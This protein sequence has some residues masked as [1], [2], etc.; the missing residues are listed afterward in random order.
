LDKL[1]EKPNLQK[2]D[3]SVSWSSIFKEYVKTHPHH[4]VI[5]KIC[6]EYETTEKDKAALRKAKSE[7]LKK[8]N[9]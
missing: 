3:E 6:A 2:K 7:Y 4:S 1:E 5:D 9:S 8:I